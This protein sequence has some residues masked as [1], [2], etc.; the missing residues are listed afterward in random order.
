MARPFQQELTKGFPEATLF[1]IL[2]RNRPVHLHALGRRRTAVI[3]SRQAPLAEPGKDSPRGGSASPP[4]WPARILPFAVEGPAGLGRR[5]AAA[6]R[7]PRGRR[8]PGQGRAGRGAAEP[9]ADHPGHRPRRP[10]GLLRLRRR[11]DPGARPP[12]ARGSALRAGVVASA[13]HAPGPFEPAL[14]PAAAAP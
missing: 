1:A 11:R 4:L 10:P 12:G 5:R 2:P 14:R 7:A 13:A 9:P 3:S 8:L 6:P